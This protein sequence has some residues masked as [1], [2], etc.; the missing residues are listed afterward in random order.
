M[1]HDNRD[2]SMGG[3]FCIL[4]QH[5]SAPIEFFFCSSPIHRSTFLSLPQLSIFTFPSNLVCVVYVGIMNEQDRAT[6]QGKTKCKTNRDNK[7]ESRTYLYI[8]HW[9]VRRGCK[10]RKGIIIKVCANGEQRREQEK[11]GW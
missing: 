6:G 8:L 2:E 4:C 9:L 10:L 1:E 7:K 11:N 3:F 5:R